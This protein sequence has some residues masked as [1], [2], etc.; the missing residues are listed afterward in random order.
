MERNRGRKPDRVPD[1]EGESSIAGEISLTPADAF[2][3]RDD[4][5]ISGPAGPGDIGPR[6]HGEPRA[7]PRTKAEPIV[8]SGQSTREKAR[9]TGDR[10][11]TGGNK[12]GERKRPGG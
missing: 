10:A 9:W 4:A 7:R 12:T 3:D 5:E 2:E 11:S 8:P 6:G 1:D